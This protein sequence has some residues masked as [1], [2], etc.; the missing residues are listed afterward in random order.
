MAKVFSAG[1][2]PDSLLTDVLADS[3]LFQV[4]TVSSFVFYA[5]TCIEKNEAEAVRMSSIMIPSFTATMA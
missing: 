2:S 1:Y 4:R 3:N 5:I